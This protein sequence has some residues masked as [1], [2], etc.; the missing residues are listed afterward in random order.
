MQANVEDALEISAKRNNF[1]GLELLANF[2]R[3]YGNWKMIAKLDF[4]ISNT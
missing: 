1:Q 4:N 3:K 2:G